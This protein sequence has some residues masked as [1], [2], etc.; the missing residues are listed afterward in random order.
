MCPGVGG[1]FWPRL[2]WAED[3]IMS[4]EE[5]RR[6]RQHNRRKR[7]LLIICMYYIAGN[8]R[9][10]GVG[11]GRGDLDTQTTGAET[12]GDGNPL[13]H[14]LDPAEAIRSAEPLE[15][16][17]IDTE[18]DSCTA[19]WE[20]FA[21]YWDCARTEPTILQTGV[22]HAGDGRPYSTGP[23]STSAFESGASDDADMDDTQATG[24]GSSGVSSGSGR[25]PRTATKT[26]QP[27]RLSKPDHSMSQLLHTFQDMER[28]QRD[29][30]AHAVSIVHSLV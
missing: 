14:D 12:D 26:P 19:Q 23:S 18:V 2:A 28:Q 21:A 7:M 6:R 3:V 9:A 8:T 16:E 17:D 1:Q 24:A 25:K 30:D 4:D 13:P 5:R 27:S 11:R 29:A 22:G 20:A 15:T 10:V